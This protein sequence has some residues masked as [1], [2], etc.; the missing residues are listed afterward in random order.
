MSTE[1]PEGYRKDAKG[2]LVPVAKIK[3]EHLLEDELVVEMVAQARALQA[4]LAEFRAAALER[5]LAFRDDLLASYGARKGGTKGNMTFRSFD[6]SLEMQVA[7][8]DRLS[9]G[10]ELHA[11]K[12]LIDE[13]IENWSQ[14]ANDNLRAIVND[15]FQVNKE[16]RLDMGRILGLR[17]L[18]IDDPKWT[19][20]MEAISNA[21]RTDT[22]RTYIRFYECDPATG[23]RRP[24]SLNIAAL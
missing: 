13:C 19:A 24:I 20:A 15:A 7:V 18:D 17:R 21:V 14:G 10:T 5:A 4:Q 2:N 3:T 22:S 8:Q 23:A 9:F 12:E 16:G 6:G 11:A 1:I